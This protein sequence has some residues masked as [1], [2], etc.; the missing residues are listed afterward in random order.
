MRNKHMKDK[1]NPLLKQDNKFYKRIFKWIYVV[2]YVFWIFGFIGVV[3]NYFTEVNLPEN[4]GGAL[5]TDIIISLLFTWFIFGRVL[6][7]NEKNSMS[8]MQGSCTYEELYDLLSNQTFHK[9]YNAGAED[10]EESELWLKI[11]GAFVPKNFI[12]AGYTL[13]KMHGSKHFYLILLN[14]NHVRYTIGTKTEYFE[15]TIKYFTET[16]PHAYYSDF[17]YYIKHEGE[18][19]K[20]LSEKFNKYI[21]E[22]NSIEDLI[23]NYT[24]FSEGVD[25]LTFCK[26]KMDINIK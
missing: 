4:Y 2:I 3:S 5:I 21:E 15:N 6:N 7:K 9:V 26:K 24:D 18:S 14:G 23:N 25:Y 8:G 22:G 17:F 10:L 13:D 1:S 12:V 16:I 19:G 20:Q 11:E